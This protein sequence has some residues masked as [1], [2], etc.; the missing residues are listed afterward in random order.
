MEANT[1]YEGKAYKDMSTSEKI[2]YLGKRY[3]A[4]AA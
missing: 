3:G 1:S 2:D 4:G